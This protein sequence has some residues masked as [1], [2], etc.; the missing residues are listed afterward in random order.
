MINPIVLLIASI[1]FLISFVLHVVAW[2]LFRPVKHMIWLAAIFIFLPVC[3]YLLFFQFLG[4]FNLIFIIVWHLGFSLA[5]IMT[6]PTIQAE[7]PSFKILLALRDSLPAGLS[8]DS[9]KNIFSRDKL[10]SDRLDDLI[11]EGLLN[12]KEGNW[13]LS[14]KGNI[15][16]AVF[17]V[18][19]RLLGL[20]LGEG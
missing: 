9:I 11:S 2:R 17:C 14:F 13:L 12:S 6:Y 7:C 5:Y 19:R 18:Y 3:G 15:L 8:Q 1:G 4:I 10:F 16:A 20:P